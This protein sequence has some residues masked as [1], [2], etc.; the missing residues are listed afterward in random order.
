M[1]SFFKKETKEDKERKRQKKH[2]DLSFNNTSSPDYTDQLDL[3]NEIHTE[4]TQTSSDSTQAS[5]KLQSNSH[6]SIDSQ[7][8]HPPLLPKPKKGI[9]K[10]MSKFGIGPTLANLSSSS[11]TPNTSTSISI[12][13][14]TSFLRNTSTNLPMVSSPKQVKHSP[15]SKLLIENSIPNYTKRNSQV[16]TGHILNEFESFVLPTIRKI[17]DV[18]LSKTC[19]SSHFLNSLVR[20][21][22]VSLE[23]LQKSVEFFKTEQNTIVVTCN[24]PK[25]G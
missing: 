2:G 5:T 11:T 12:V 10:T 23:Q 7:A 24:L 20:C 4:T 18:V 22:S 8:S 16:M 14:Q 15:Q 25:Y 9:L 3:T 21:V 19:D 1:K 6:T 13:N 17:P